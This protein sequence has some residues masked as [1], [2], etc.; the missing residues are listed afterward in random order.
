MTDQDS[1][2]PQ[3][4][5]ATL[6]VRTGKAKAAVRVKVTNGGLLAIGGLVS[7]ILLST[8]ALVWASTRVAYRHPV[9]TGLFHRR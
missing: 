9:A 8:A 6:V 7:S 2:R 1:F 5:S 3:A 4:N